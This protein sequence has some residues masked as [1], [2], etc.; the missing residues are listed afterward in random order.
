MMASDTAATLLHKAMRCVEAVPYRNSN[1]SGHHPVTLVSMDPSG[2]PSA[3]TVIPREI[4]KDFSFIRLN[5][6]Q[7]GAG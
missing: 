7:G 4:A 6:K 3:R 1:D 2:F 5:T